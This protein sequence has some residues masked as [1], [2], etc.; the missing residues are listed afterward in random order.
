MQQVRNFGDGLRRGLG[1]LIRCDCGKTV[2]FRCSDFREHVPEDANVEAYRWRCSWCG[3]VA[4][5]V[6]Y[7]A[8]DRNDREGLAQWRPPSWWPQRRS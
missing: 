5:S 8:L 1:I 3:R 6:R 2:R 4:S 7:V